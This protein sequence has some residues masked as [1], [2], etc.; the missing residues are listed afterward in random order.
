MVR[1][2]KMIIYPQAL[3]YTRLKM[4]LRVDNMTNNGLDLM[5]FTVESS[6]L[7]HAIWHFWIIARI[8][9]NGTYITI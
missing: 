3:E 7:P 9:I 5:S 4:G 8:T 6:F 1:K 2:G